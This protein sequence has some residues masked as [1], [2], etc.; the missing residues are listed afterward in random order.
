MDTTTLST[1]TLEQRL[2]TGEATI[3][4]IR[5][6]QMTILREIDRRQTPT[7]DGSRS[8]VEWVTGRL[9][10]SPETAKA[11]VSTSRRLE[12][13]PTVEQAAGDGSI[14]FDRTTV[15]AQIAVPSDDETIID[16]LSVYDVAGI[17]RLRS[18]RHRVTRGMEREAFETRYVAV[19]ANLDESSWRVHGHLP[20]GA[21]RCFVQALDTKADVLPADPDGNRTRT[22]RYADALWAISIDSLSGGDGATI[23]T[24]TPLLTV[25]VDA[26]DAAVSNG[27]T[28]VVIEAGPR[29]GPDT[30]EAILC[31]GIIEVTARA[32]DGTPVNM[33]RRSRT[34]PPRLKRFILARRVHRCRLCQPL[35]P[36]TTPH[37]P[38]VTRRT[39]QRH[40]PHHPVLVP[41]PRCDP[42]TRIHHQPRITHPT[43]TT[44]QTTNPRTTPIGRELSSRYEGTKDPVA[45]SVRGRELIV[46]LNVRR[47]APP[48]LLHHRTKSWRHRGSGAATKRRC[49]I[50]RL[51]VTEDTKASEILDE[52]GDIADVM[53][54]L[55]MKRVGSLSFRRVVTKAIAVNQAARIHRVPVDGLLDTLNTAVAQIEGEDLVAGT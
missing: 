17:R 23:E 50:G 27:E 5:N 51:E 54:A 9:D 33:G 34:I 39:H 38:M 28:G 25:F 47:T 20:G 29:V 10:V 6:A 7:A 40:Q 2:V 4:K 26:H 36:T 55:G 46:S 44:P 22:T 48:A 21:G 14:S 12:A 16:E 53:E 1:D 49:D 15:V 13:L 18:N 35:P 42:R 37:H 24:S 31:D 43:Q 19:Q 52:Y 30:V 32:T 8:M 11:L 45:R 41:P 3:A